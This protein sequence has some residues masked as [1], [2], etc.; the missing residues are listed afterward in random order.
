MNQ[1]QTTKKPI[2]ILWISRHPIQ[3]AQLDELRDRFGV[4]V[5]IVQIRATF[6][7]L[8]EIVAAAEREHAD[9][10]VAILPLKLLAALCTTRW[11][12][13]RPVMKPLNDTGKGDAT[14]FEHLR[15][16]RVDSIQLV[17]HPILQETPA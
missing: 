16:E 2:R 13:I 5:E 3:A 8:D 11:K 1:E 17:T 12:P 10:I 4:D 9:E 15:F 7:N 6:R 14:E